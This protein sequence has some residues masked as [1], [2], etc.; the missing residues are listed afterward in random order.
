[1]D[2]KKEEA[3]DSGLFYTAFIETNKEL[4]RTTFNMIPYMKCKA[5]LINLCI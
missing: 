4:I 5:K 2:T 3:A 1:M